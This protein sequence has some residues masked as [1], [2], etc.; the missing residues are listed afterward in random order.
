MTVIQIQAA[1]S[2]WLLVGIAV[3]TV[4]LI[5][6]FTGGQSD[7]DSR[8]EISQT[9]T[10]ATVIGPNL[11]AIKEGSPL[12][13]KLAITEVSLER[14]S[15]PI[16][17]VT[18]AVMARLKAGNEPTVNRWQFSSVEL[19]AM[20]S[21]WQKAKAEM[22][23]AGKALQKTKELTAA[24]LTSQQK[25]VDR[26]RK[27][28]ATGTEAVRD[29]TTAEA[30]LLEAQLEGQ[31]NIFE[32][33]SAQM[34][35]THSHADLERQL[36]GSG[37]DPALLSHANAGDAM[38]MAEVPEVRVSLV[39]SGQTCSA[40]FY[41]LP[42]QKFNGIVRSLSPALSTERRTLRIFFELDDERNQ[43]KPG[44]YAEIGLGTEPRESV[45]A[46]ADGVLHIGD[47]DYVLTAADPG[48]WRV[49]PVQVGE[50]AGERVEI[51]S[52]LSAGE[53]LI[54]HGSILIKPLVVRAILA[55]RKD[56]QPEGDDP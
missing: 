42:N 36:L 48:Q 32:A 20:Y 18:G 53:R 56:P 2:R 17:T 7:K 19:S 44:M 4:L 24:Q 30:N 39:S 49:T 16:L 55:A 33:E 54:G 5:V 26:L 28:V 52:G 8:S 46:S 38:V 34:Q 10:T 43:L 25:V 22:D 41:G 37:V 23:F 29:L 6:R 27:L 11:I 1:R 35:A 14:I 12:E 21:D 50:R 9:D 31:K 40:N 3:I 13:K 45:L 15:T 47:T 51:L